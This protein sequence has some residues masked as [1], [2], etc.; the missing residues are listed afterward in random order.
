[1][2]FYPVCL[3]I[4]ILGG[5]RPIAPCPPPLLGR[6]VVISILRSG[7]RGPDC[8][9]FCFSHASV[10]TVGSTVELLVDAQEVNFP[11]TGQ[12]TYHLMVGRGHD[13]HHM[14]SGSANNGI[15]RAHVLDNR[16]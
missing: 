1:M 8:R 10:L 5:L 13:F 12:V 15:I 6:R 2:W 14:Q 16:K 4:L 9:S 11:D 3:G 7:S